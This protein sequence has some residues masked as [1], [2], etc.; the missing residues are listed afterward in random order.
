MDPLVAAALVAAVV[1]GGLPPMFLLYL[2]LAQREY[3]AP[4]FTDVRGLIMLVGGAL[5]LCL[6]IFWMSKLVKVDV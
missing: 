4:L 1:L 3:V 5:W 6:G 2:T